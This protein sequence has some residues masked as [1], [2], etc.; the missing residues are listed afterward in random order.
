MNEAP[1]SNWNERPLGLT[2]E[3]I[4]IV[5]DEETYALGFVES[6]ARFV[7]FRLYQC[8]YYYNTDGY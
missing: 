6:A 4:L 1:P 3:Q 7:S 5:E 8:L 2:K